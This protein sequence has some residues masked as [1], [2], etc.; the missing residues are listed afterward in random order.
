MGY[1]IDDEE[2]E[3]GIRSIGAP[4]L[5]D[6]CQLVASISI[7]GP[8][9]QIQNISALALQVRKAAATLAATWPQWMIR[10]MHP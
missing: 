2:E 7:S 5:D 1:A 4:I 8:T 9:P 6:K 10:I 3:I